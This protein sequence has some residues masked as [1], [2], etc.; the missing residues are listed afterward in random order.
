MHSLTHIF[1]MDHFHSLDVLGRL[2]SSYTVMLFAFELYLMSVFYCLKCIISLGISSELN[3]SSVDTKL[4]ITIAKNVAKT[5][6][7]FCVK[8][9]QLVC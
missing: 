6:K 8:S 3:V 7:L 1:C 5:V 2:F 9:E 4:S